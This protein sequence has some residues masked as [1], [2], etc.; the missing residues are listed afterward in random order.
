MKKN[1]FTKEGGKPRKQGRKP[2]ACEQGLKTSGELWMRG[3]L[4]YLLYGIVWDDGVNSYGGV[5]ASLFQRVHVF[6]TSNK[7]QYSSCR[8]LHVQML[9]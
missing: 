5:S 1:Y 3:M 6:R 8:F 4:K 2:G 7:C 9:H